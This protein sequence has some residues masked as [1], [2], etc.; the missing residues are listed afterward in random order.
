MI[1]ICGIDPGYGGGIAFYCDKTITAVPMPKT[2][3]EIWDYLEYLKETYGNFIVFIERVQM[4]HG[5]T[6]GNQGKKF[7][8][9]KM[10]GQYKSLLALIEANRIPIVE[11]AP[12]TWQK[13]L[14]LYFPKKEKQQRKNLYKRFAA[15]EFPTIKPTLKTA[16]ALCLVQFGK[17]RC[18]L[19]GTWVKQNIINKESLTLFKAS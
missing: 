14:G 3:R 13:E 9:T 7:G 10:I 5:D 12:I 8:I 15:K 19:S 2:N 17:V 18:T 1:P 4:W 16:D 6:T 11:V